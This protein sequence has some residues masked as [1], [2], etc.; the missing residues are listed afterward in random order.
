MNYSRSFCF[1]LFKL[2][3]NYRENIYFYEM[4]LVY[5]IQ[6]LNID[7]NEGIKISDVVIFICLLFLINSISFCMCKLHTC[8]II[9]ITCLKSMEK[10]NCER[11]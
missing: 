11:K 1:Y 5:V 8:F 7:I 2:Y 3:L 6:M 9:K 4:T 10:D